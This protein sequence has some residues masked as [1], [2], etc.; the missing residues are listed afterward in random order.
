MK[1]RK[2]APSKENK[3]FI[4]ES[5]GGYNPCIEIGGGSVLPNCTGYA[6]GRFHEWG[7]VHPFKYRFVH[8]AVDFWDEAKSAGLK[9]GQVPKLGAIAV[10]SGHT[11]G[12]VEIVEQIQNMSAGK[13]GKCNFSSSAYGGERFRF[14]TRNN[15]DGAWGYA[16]RG[17][18]FLGFIYNPYV[19]MKCV[20]TM[21]KELLKGGKADVAYDFNGDGKV[22][23]KDLLVLRKS[24]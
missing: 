3:Y 10:W 19:N 21:R 2:T 11:F 22:G 16:S 17:Y 13:D 9:T 4:C 15:S 1:I 23:L 14:Y 7:G 12:H 5:K 24:L 6:L 18:K 8:D 20:L